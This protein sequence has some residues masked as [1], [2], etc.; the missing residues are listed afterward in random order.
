MLP[1]MVLYICDSTIKTLKKVFYTNY[2]IIFYTHD[3]V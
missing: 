3:I 1:D 2:I